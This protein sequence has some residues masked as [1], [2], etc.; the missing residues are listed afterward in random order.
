[1]QKPTVSG[2]FFPFASP[3]MRRGFWKRWAQEELREWRHCAGMVAPAVL[4]AAVDPQT[5]AAWD[6]GADSSPAEASQ[7]NPT[8][9]NVTAGSC[10]PSDPGFPP[11]FSVLEMWTSPLNGVRRLIAWCGLGAGRPMCSFLY[12]FLSRTEIAA[13]N[14]VSFTPEALCQWST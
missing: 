5:S 12:Q 10:S 11:L 7:L 1:M 14:Y 8:M 13:Q 6:L 9:R 2:W 4:A 3:T